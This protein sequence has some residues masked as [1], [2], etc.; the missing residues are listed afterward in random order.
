MA[1]VSY[2]SIGTTATLIGTFS[3]TTNQTL[4]IHVDA[5]SPPVW[6]GTSNSV[7]TS[8]GFPA[9]GGSDFVLQRGY[10][11]GDQQVW[12]I[13]TGPYAGNVTWSVNVS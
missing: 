4:R 7:T 8:N 5:A 9:G 13:V 1:P 3:G 2:L 10:A 6:F 11:S 12:G